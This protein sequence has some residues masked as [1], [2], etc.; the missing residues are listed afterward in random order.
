M[1]RFDLSQLYE[2]REGKPTEDKAARVIAIHALIPA[3]MIGLL[4]ATQLF[5]ERVPFGRVAGVSIAAAFGCGFG[6]LFGIWA[7]Y[8]VFGF[9]P[10]VVIADV[11]IGLFVGFGLGLTLEL[12]FDRWWPAVAGPVVG[13]VVVPL[14]GYMRSKAARRTRPGDDPPAPEARDDR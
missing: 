3:A 8:R 1:A 14:L 9:R 4:A 11:V 7:A 5:D 6:T 2:A 10:V 12:L 13:A